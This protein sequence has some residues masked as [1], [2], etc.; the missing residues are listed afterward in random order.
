MLWNFKFKRFKGLKLKISWGKSCFFSII[1]P[2]PKYS[3]HES[4]LQISL[5]KQEKY[6]FRQKMVF[7]LVILRENM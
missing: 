6:Q 2:A 3:E 1:N 7:T 5:D 4:T